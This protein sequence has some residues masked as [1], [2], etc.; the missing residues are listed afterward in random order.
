M[1]IEQWEDHRGTHPVEDLI[2]SQPPKAQAKIAWTIGLLES[3]GTNLLRTDHMTRLHGCKPPIYELRIRTMG[4]FY[5]IL[6]V[7]LDN[8]AWLLHGFTKQTDKTPR[9]HITIAIKRAEE[10]ISKL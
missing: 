7:I 6:F 8:T 4:K 2:V 10:L 9:N 5:R 3:Q 1:E